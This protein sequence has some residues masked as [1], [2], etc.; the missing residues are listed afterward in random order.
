MRPLLFKI[1]PPRRVAHFFDALGQP[2]FEDS[3]LH[4]LRQGIYHGGLHDC[5]LWHVERG[6]T[7]KLMLVADG[8]KRRLPLT[9]GRAEQLLIYKPSTRLKLA[10]FAEQWAWWRACG[11]GIFFEDYSFVDTTK[12][13]HYHGIGLRA[14]KKNGMGGLSFRGGEI[15]DRAL[16]DPEYVRVI[17]TDILYFYAH[18]RQAKRQ[19]HLEPG[20]LPEQLRAAFVKEMRRKVEKLGIS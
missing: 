6:R 16:S 11:W 7:G 15:L 3:Y 19:A 13:E 2:I 1:Q 5:F 17:L 14:H 18:P 4:L 20:Q 9:A 10:D 12:W 8:I